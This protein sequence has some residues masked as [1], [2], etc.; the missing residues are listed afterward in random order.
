MPGH[1]GQRRWSVVV[2]A[3]RNGWHHIWLMGDHDLT[4]CH[5]SRIQARSVPRINPMMYIMCEIGLT[6]ALARIGYGHWGSEATMVQQTDH[7]LRY[8]ASGSGYLG[9]ALPVQVL[10]RALQL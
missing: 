9:W 1:R 5:V 10:P 7:S 2:D 6:N 4:I 8:L 3:L